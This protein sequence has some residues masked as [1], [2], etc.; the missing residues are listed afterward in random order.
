MDHRQAGGGPGARSAPSPRCNGCLGYKLYCVS[1]AAAAGRLHY[2]GTALGSVR[3]LFRSFGEPYSVLFLGA[4]V[5]VYPRDEAAS[6]ELDQR[7][8]SCMQRDLKA[9]ANEPTSDNG[10]VARL[11]HF[12]RL[13]RAVPECERYA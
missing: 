13:S 2:G 6:L 7:T 1:E 5:G 9:M 4:R 3:F 10:A 12:Q 11:F 8:A